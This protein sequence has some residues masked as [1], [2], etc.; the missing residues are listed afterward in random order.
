MTASNTLSAYEK[1]L[2]TE[3]EALE[4]ALVD[5]MDDLYDRAVDETRR[6]DDLHRANQSQYWAH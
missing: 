1:G 2:I 4:Q 5:T 3:S 6:A